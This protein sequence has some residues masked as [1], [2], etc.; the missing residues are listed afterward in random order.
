MHHV[1]CCDYGDSALNADTSLIVAPSFV[2]FF[3]N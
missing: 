1:N 2:R 3:A